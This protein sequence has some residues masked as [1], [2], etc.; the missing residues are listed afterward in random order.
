MIQR[1]LE[2]RAYVLTLRGTPPKSS[3]QFRDRSLNFLLSHYLQET[4]FASEEDSGEAQHDVNT[5]DVWLGRST[6]IFRLVSTN[7]AKAL[8]RQR[9]P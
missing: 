1:G 6:G 7:S 2:A 8:S 5:H 9:L 3:G 4:H